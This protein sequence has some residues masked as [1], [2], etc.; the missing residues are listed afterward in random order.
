M[1]IA[2]AGVVVGGLF[3]WAVVAYALGMSLVTIV[4]SELGLFFALFGVVEMARPGTSAPDDGLTVR[5]Q[6][7]RRAAPID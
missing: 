1:A 6:V 3:F 4:L 7:R 5:E 2:K